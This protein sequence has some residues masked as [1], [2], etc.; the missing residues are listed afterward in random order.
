MNRQLRAASAALF[1]ALLPAVSLFVTPRP[2][3]ADGACPIVVAHRTMPLDRP[4]NTVAGIQAV[5]A[6]GARTV[7]M[8]VQWSSSGFPVLM[9]DTTVDRTTNGTGTPASMGL[10]KLTGLLAQDYAPWKGS[11]AY[12][13]V[14]VP[15]GYDFMDAV[16]SNN[17]DVLLHVTTDPTQVGTQKLRVYV[18]DYFGWT[19]HSIVMAE[20][21][22]VAAM[23]GWEPGL[24]YAVIEYLGDRVPTP[25]YLK[26]LGAVAYVIPWDAASPALVG[27][28]HESGI[29]L[30]AWTSDLPAYDIPA[31][32]TAL[33]AAGVDA[34]ITNRP[35]AVLA[36]LACEGAP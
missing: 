12:F 7:E 8:D 10:S 27:Y 22:R 35:A 9:H 34:V 19:Q 6:T 4:E 36:A 20:A 24:R 30:Y 33:A 14:H 18:N 26:S 21:D 29:K 2:A 1:A 32:W 25:A 17:L 28:Y 3:A 15:Y 13:G 23:H 5:P 31:N 11:P 16:A